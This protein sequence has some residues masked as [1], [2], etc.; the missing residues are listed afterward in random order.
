[1]SK[2]ERV[3]RTSCHCSGAQFFPCS[4][5]PVRSNAQNDTAFQIETRSALFQE[6]FSVRTQR[7]DATNMARRMKSAGRSQIYSVEVVQPAV[8]YYY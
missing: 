3:R 4:V 5:H 6:I 2:A 8:C 7:H 1:M